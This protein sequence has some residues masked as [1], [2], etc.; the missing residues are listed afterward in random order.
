MIRSVTAFTRSYDYWYDR[1]QLYYRAGLREECARRGIPYGEVGMTRATHALRPVRAWRDRYL[2]RVPVKAVVAG[3]DAAAQLLE[4]PVQ[5]PAGIFHNAVGQYLVTTESAERRIC[6]DSTDYPTLPS[7]ELVRWGDLY[8]KSNRWPSHDYPA[9]VLPLINGDPLILRRIGSLRRARQTPKRWDVCF[10][11][12]V[13]GGRD[14]TEAIEH[15]VLLLESLNKAQASKMLIAY[16]VAGDVAALSRRLRAA[17]IRCRRHSV[18]AGRLWEMMAQSRLNVIRLGM[19]SCIPWRMTGALAMGACVVLDQPPRSY[20]PVPLSVNDNFLSLGLRTVDS[21][22]AASGLYEAVP[23]KIAAWLAEPEMVQRMQLM[24]ADYFDRFV[25]PVKV[26]AYIL[27][28]VE[29]NG[30]QSPG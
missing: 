3:V 1:Y 18:R 19:H 6:V 2:S 5:A 17:G 8:F 29:E 16:L 27:D 26:G 30:R 13:W 20:W 22:L 23:E 25:D 15:N 7:E 11:V 21:A 10:V 28:S 9:N 24:N 14:A 4:G 12:R